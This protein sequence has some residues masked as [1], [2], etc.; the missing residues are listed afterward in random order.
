[1]A[2]NSANERSLA[3]LLIYQLFGTISEFTAMGLPL[4]VGTLVLDYLVLEYNLVVS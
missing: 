4:A 2:Q 1:M 3:S